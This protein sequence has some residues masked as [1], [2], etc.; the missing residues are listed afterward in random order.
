MSDS[1]AIGQEVDS[2]RAGQA[3]SPPTIRLLL[4][5]VWRPLIVVLVI[6]TI[7]IVARPAEIVANIGEWRE[8]IESHGLL[9]LAVFLAIYV[10]AA[11]AIVPQAVLKVAA[12]GLFGSLLGVI[13]A[14]IGSTLGATTC[15][16]ISRYVARGTLM[17]RLKQGPRFKRLDLMTH[18][19]GALIVAVSRL[20]PIFPGNLINYAFG[21]TQVRLRTFVFW[22]WLCMLPG[23][24]VLVVGT[25]ALV[26]GLEERR[27]PWGLVAIVAGTLA[28]LVAIVITIHR[29]FRIKQDEGGDIADL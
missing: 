24:V 15:F 4:R 9:G 13:I 5:G 20:I 10:L 3:D 17:K 2:T 23:T 26:Q 12:G 14:S 8:W 21:L 27:V 18:K 7:I 11:V 19:H 6:A 25:D 22:S 1:R 28:G 16:L 29:R